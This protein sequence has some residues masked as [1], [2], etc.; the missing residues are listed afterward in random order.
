MFDVPLKRFGS[1]HVAPIYR[2]NSGT[3]YSLSVSGV[4]LSAIQAARNPGYDTAPTQTLYFGAR[5]SESFKGY[6]LVD[7][8][9]TYDVP[10][11]RKASPWIKFESFNLLN[12]QKL[13][14]WD[15]TITVDP[16]GPKDAD[17]LP[18]AYIQGPKFGQAISPA[19]YPAPRPGL[20]GGRMVDVAVGFRF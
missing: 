9:L 2:Y 10:V 20:D 15:K 12:N 3:T 6:A 13:I 19:N 14:S 4:P 16:N 8:A 1:V 5:G 7:L 17:G 11:W 18:T